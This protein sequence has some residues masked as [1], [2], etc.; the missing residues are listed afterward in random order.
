MGRGSWH[1]INVSVLLALYSFFSSLFVVLPIL[2]QS[3]DARFVCVALQTKYMLV[4]TETAKLLDLFPYDRETDTPFIKRVES[5]RVV[6]MKNWKIEYLLSS[7]HNTTETAKN[8]VIAHIETLQFFSLLQQLFQQF[9]ILAKI[10][11]T[12]SKRKCLQF[13]L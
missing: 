5:V 4:D 8:A 10:F 11:T 9:Y 1:S 3:M 7:S 13:Q 6:C 12:I 2:F